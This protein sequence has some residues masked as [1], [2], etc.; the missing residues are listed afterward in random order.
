MALTQVSSGML[1]NTGVSA[2]TYGGA[3]TVPVVTVNA[4]GQ[5][6]SAA[7]VT[8]SIAN[9]QITGTINSTQLTNTGVSSGTYGGST[10]IPVLV[11][12]AQGQITSA[13]N[14]SITIPPSTAIYANSGQLTANSSTGNV[15]LGLATA[16]TAGTYGAV[17][18]IPIITTDAYGRVT[19]VSNTAIALTSGQVTTALG[20]TPYNSSNPS[21]YL[22]SSGAVTSLTGTSNQIS[23][24]GSTGAVT[25]S[26]PQSIG[27]GSSVQF[28]SFGVGT[29]ASGT[30]GEIR[31]TGNITAG[32]SDDE[33]KVKLGNIENA[34]EK[35]LSLNGFYYQANQTAQELGYT[36]EKQ[37]GVSAQEVQ[38]V[39]PEVVVP[40]PISDK[41]LTVQYEKLIP[42]LIEAIKEQQ[43]QI[44]ALMQKVK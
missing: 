37:V 10:A 38:N 39:L 23:V 6:T 25:L 12:N 30:T 16:G 32:Y 20:Y 21:G 7:N 2:G 1:G 18:Y 44:D 31:A 42:L 11:V 5:V 41:Y 35:L 34:L 3:G 40:A 33:L 13:A 8:A 19:T 4:E 9:T 15:L 43:K 26:T 22:T 27:T 29:A 24:S 14:A 17:N 36:T 28:G